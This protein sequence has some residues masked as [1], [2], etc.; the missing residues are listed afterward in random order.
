MYYV[1]SCMTM[2]LPVMLLGPQKVAAIT[3]RKIL[4]VTVFPF[5]SYTRNR[6]VYHKNYCWHSAWQKYR[7]QTT[8]GTYWDSLI[9]SRGVVRIFLFW[10]EIYAVEY[11][12]ACDLIAYI[13]EINNKWYITLGTTHMNHIN[14]RKT[15]FLLHT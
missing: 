4:Q 15:L 1:M 9:W 8:P 12:K 14:I 2:F 11:N 5:L 6:T 13:D 7:G 3:Y 10:H